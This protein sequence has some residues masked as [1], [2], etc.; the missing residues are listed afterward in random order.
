[1]ELDYFWF[2][3]KAAVQPFR[4]LLP[5]ARGR[6]P[7][8]FSDIQLGAGDHLPILSHLAARQLRR[9]RRPGSRRR[10]ACTLVPG[11]RHVPRRR[12]RHWKARILAASAVLA[13][14]RH[15]SIVCHAFEPPL[16]L[17]D[18]GDFFRFSH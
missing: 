15:L 13:A 11:R 16:R 12:P 4:T 6:A 3:P 14:V 9:V 1:M 18:G 17:R 5:L 8:G 10:R 7:V 2:W